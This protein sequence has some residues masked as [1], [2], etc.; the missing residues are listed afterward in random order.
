MNEMFSTAPLTHFISVEIV[1]FEMSQAD[2]TSIPADDLY[3]LVR[4]VLRYS[5]R[6]RQV[7][8]EPL[9]SA[10]GLNTKE[11]LVLSAIMDGYDTPSAVAERQSLPAPTVSRMVSKLVAEGLIERLTDP[12]D[13]RR[14]RLMLTPQGAEA[15]QDIRLR[16]QAMVQEH[17][18][19]LN[20]AD[21]AAAVSA[22]Q[23]LEEGL[24]RPTQEANA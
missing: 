2:P 17:F 22:L 8:D 23:T 15:R 4:T 6:F 1:S 18:G 3:V 12:K 19:H 16:A 10:F 11:I 20:P 7:L 14:Q 5:R 13:L 21:L 24:F 9:E